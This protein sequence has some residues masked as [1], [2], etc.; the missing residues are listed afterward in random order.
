MAAVVA[1]WVF[2]AKGPAELLAPPSRKQR[3]AVPAVTGGRTLQELA[4]RMV[5]VV[6]FI[7]PVPQMA[8]TALSA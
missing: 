4:G 1:A 7:L 3:E 8:P 5:V 6:G 2:L